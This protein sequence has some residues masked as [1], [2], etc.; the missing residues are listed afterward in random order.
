[1]NSATAAM[2]MSLRI[3]GV[4]PGDEV[5]TSAYTYTAS[6]SVIEHVGADIVLID[7][8]R[9]S[10][11]MDYRKLE[12]SIN[13]RTKVIIPVDIGGRICDYEKIHE[14]VEAKKNIYVPNNDIQKRFGKIVVMADAAH[15]FGAK[16][17]GKNSGQLAD[18]SCFS[19]HAVKN[20][21]TAEGGAVVWNNDYGLGDDWIYQQFMLYS[22][23]GQSKDALAK[24]TLGSWEYDIIYPAYKCNM[25]DVLAAIGLSQLG[26]YEQMLA[27]RRE[28][29]ERYDDGLRSFGVTSM[30]HFGDKLSSSCHLYLA[31]IPDIEE[32]ERNNLIVRMAELGIAT[33]VH[34]KPLPMFTAYKNL[35]FNISD[36][37]NAFGMYENEISLPLHTRLT[38]DDI[39]YVIDSL[40]KSLSR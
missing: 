25:T 35:G 1:M 22:L 29:V 7:T 33:N 3:L 39:D 38:N 4:G 24:T 28:I 30:Q 36:Y 34:Y 37:P 16:R 20:L 13:E 31:R 14:I 5:I 23:H 18:I 21:T 2:E 8:S 11:E 9:D 40:K 27:R 32:K 10:F 12:D 26:R 17:N 19:F 6:A 15:S